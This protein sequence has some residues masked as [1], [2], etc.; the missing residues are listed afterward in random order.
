MNLFDEIIDRKN[1]ASSK[2]NPDYLNSL[3]FSEEVLPFWIADMDFKSPAPM[4]ENIKQRADYGIL[5][6]EYSPASFYSSLIRWVEKHHHYPLAKEHIQASPSIGTSIAVAINCLSEEGDG[7]IIQPPVFMEYMNFIKN[8]NRRIVKNKLKEEN[9]KYSIDFEDLE[10][11]ARDPRTKL[12]ILCNPHNPIG[13][14][15]NF[16][17]LTRMMQICKENNVFVLSDE[18]HADIVYPPNHFDGCLALD[19]KFHSHIISLYSPVKTFNLGGFSDSFIFIKDPEL[20]E[21]ISSYMKKY[22]LGKTNGIIRSALEEAFNSS[23]QWLKELIIYLNG[24][25][26][27]IEKMINENNLPIKFHR[28]EASYQLWLDFRESGMNAKEV[29]EFLC[30]KAKLGMNAGFWFG[31]EGIGFTRMNIASPR[32]VVKEGMER[33]VAA[34]KK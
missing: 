13:Q 16:K 25:I 32:S 29:H 18:V 21:Q 22:L 10:L 9:G 34:F 11:K 12:L 33:L 14:I 1:V 30:K 24:N 27:L 19:P 26:D 23:E 6:Y 4:L 5:A 3:F 8:N 15:W 28:P 31:S 2:W 7:V 17:E 20:K